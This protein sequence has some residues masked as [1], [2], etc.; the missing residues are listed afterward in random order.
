MARTSFPLLVVA[1]L[2]ASLLASCGDDGAGGSTTTPPTVV[3]TT[4]ATTTTEPGEVVTGAVFNA[5]DRSP[6]TDV[7]V[8]LCVEDGADACVIDMSLLAVTDAAGLFEIRGVPDGTHAL[9]YSLAATTH[10]DWDG[11]HGRIDPGGG[12]TRDDILAFLGADDIRS[13]WIQTTYSGTGQ[14]GVS[15]FVYSPGLELGFVWVK[16]GP[17]SV[18]VSGLPEMVDFPVWDTENMPPTEDFRELFP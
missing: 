13:P 18:E 10:E 1:L 5:Y 9:L 14:S 17:L 2:S 8:V 11:M 4:I 7:P 16:D 6:M 15:A 12:I 3:T